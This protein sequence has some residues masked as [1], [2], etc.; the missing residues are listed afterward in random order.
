MGW[1]LY[2]NGG[3]GDSIDRLPTTDQFS[4]SPTTARHS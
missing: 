2:G 3:P 1:T 4:S